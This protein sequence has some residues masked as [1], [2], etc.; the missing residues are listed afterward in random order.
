MCTCI[1]GHRV[2][3]EILQTCENQNMFHGHQVLM[4]IS[5]LVMQF[6]V[7]CLLYYVDHYFSSFCEY[8]LLPRHI[9]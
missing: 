1:V 9:A 8:T 6:C 2:M 5:I 4:F 3:C 7:F